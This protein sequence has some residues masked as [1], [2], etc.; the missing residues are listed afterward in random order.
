MKKIF[1]LFAVALMSASMFADPNIVT[2][3]ISGETEFTDSVIV[4]MSCPSPNADIYYTT[5]GT[6]DPK[7]D[8]DAAP[9]YKKPIIIRETTVIK[10]A[11]FDGD[12]W[13]GVAEV[14]FTKVAARPDTAFGVNHEEE[15]VMAIYCN[16]YATNN[17]NFNVLGWGDVTTWETLKLGEDSTNVLYCQDMKW[18]MMTNWDAE[19]Y[20]LSSYAKMHFDLW[21]PFA[22]KMK[23]TF[24]AKS[25]WKNGVVFTLNEGWNTIDA[26]P[27]WWNTDSVTYN[28][29]DV[30]Y[31]AFEGYMK[32]DTTSA[33]G[34]PFAFANVYFWNEP[35]PKNIPATAPAVPTMAEDLVQALFSAT[36]QTRTFNFAPTK[37]G[38]QDWLDYAYTNGQHI[39]YTE[40]M[41]WDGFTNW[42]ASSY[43]LT[44]YDMMHADVYV[45]V[46][47]KLKFTFEALSAGDG[48]SGWKNGT[49]VDLVAN[50]WNSI[51]VDLLASPLD[52]YDFTDMRYLI[53]EGFKNPD[54]SSAEGTPLAIANVYFW[55]SMNQ[56]LKDAQSGKTATKV[57]RDGQLII[58]KNGVEYNAVGTKF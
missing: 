36:Y 2:P 57:L 58:I 6:T 3:T 50:Q 13:S 14:T 55:N 40:A 53:L 44:E 26:D 16:H 30:K 10:A 19:S 11:A 27:A 4:T 28:W 48:G 9:E 34:N 39:W 31:I 8:C 43:N 38:V 12:D 47:S 18:E 41:T 52:S 35:A 46:A 15:D 51:D 33:E 24:E 21:V 54:G 17:Y 20:D 37:W 56:G 42:D 25:G 32:N 7:C 49:S 45:T 29:T 22:S 1:S 23:V 5:D